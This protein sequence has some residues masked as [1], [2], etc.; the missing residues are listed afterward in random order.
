MSDNLKFMW[1]TKH[2]NWVVRWAT[3]DFSL[4]AAL[5]KPHKLPNNSEFKFAWNKSRP[6]SEHVITKL[7]TVRWEFGLLNNMQSW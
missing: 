2:T 4:A 7:S 3:Q 1:T 6:Y 5:H